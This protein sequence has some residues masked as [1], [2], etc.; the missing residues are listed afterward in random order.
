MEPRVKIALPSCFLE[1][2]QCADLPPTHSS[3]VGGGALDLVKCGALT[4]PVSAFPFL[5]L[6]F[7][8]THS[9]GLP[10]NFLG[11]CLPQTLKSQGHL[12]PGV[13]EDSFFSFLLLEWK[14]TASLGRVLFTVQWSS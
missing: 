11:S 9:P 8:P 5:Y 14:K 4:Y 13:E 6:K 10:A 12:S 3:K 1:V 7:F 2:S